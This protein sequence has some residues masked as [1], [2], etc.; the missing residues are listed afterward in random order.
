MGNHH[1]DTTNHKH[2]NAQQCLRLALSLW[3][4]LGQWYLKLLQKLLSGNAT[5]LNTEA[6]LQIRDER[7]RSFRFLRIQQNQS[8]IELNNKYRDKCCG[9]YHDRCCPLTHIKCYLIPR[10]MSVKVGRLCLRF[11]LYF[12]CPWEFACVWTECTLNNTI[13]LGVQI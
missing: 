3:Q 9:S 12:W 10:E 8:Y 13:E 11:Y 1:V 5:V 2:Q 4:F 6:A 7:I